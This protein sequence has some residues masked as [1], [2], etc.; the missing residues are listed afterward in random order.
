MQNQSVGK[1]C[2]LLHCQ[3]RIDRGHA[4]L[5]TTLILKWNVEDPKNQPRV[6]QTVLL[7]QGL[8][9]WRLR[10]GLSLFTSHW[11]SFPFQ[12]VLQHLFPTHIPIPDLNGLFPCAFQQPITL[13][14][15]LC[16]ANYHQ[17]SEPSCLSSEAILDPVL[18]MSH[19]PR[20]WHQCGLCP[21][22]GSFAWG[23]QQDLALK[24]QGQCSNR[25]ILYF[26]I[27]V[28]SR[29]FVQGCSARVIGSTVLYALCLCWTF[30]WQSAVLDECWI[31]STPSGK[32][33]DTM[34]SPPITATL[35][36]HFHTIILLFPSTMSEDIN[37]QL[38]KYKFVSHL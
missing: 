25:R 14:S 31:H 8:H 20:G 24:D 23:N 16:S 17:V 19:W 15:G 1:V 13:F 4:V 22:V 36:S 7:P 32:V 9:L 10:A 2:T 3:K 29:G 34:D 21:G 30:R 35:L 37:Q 33:L 11:W 38:I 27:N 5:A 18:M 26:L 6:H 12:R 28:V